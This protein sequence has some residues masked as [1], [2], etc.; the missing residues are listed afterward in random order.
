MTT[1]GRPKME[2]DKRK[3]LI[4]ISVSGRIKKIA[5]FTGNASGFFEMAAEAYLKTKVGKQL[6]TDLEVKDAQ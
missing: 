1:I 3:V 6:L 4:S 2:P 5:E